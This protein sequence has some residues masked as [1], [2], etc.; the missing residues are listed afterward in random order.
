[1]K[2]A[3][4]AMLLALALPQFALAHQRAILSVQEVPQ[5][6]PPKAQTMCWEWGR[7]AQATTLSWA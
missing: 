6:D 7:L 1:M 5:S 4:C 2:L 3:K